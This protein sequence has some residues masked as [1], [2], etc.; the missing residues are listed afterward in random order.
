[1]DLL[2]KL[3]IKNLK[4][5]KKRTI[6]TIIGIM[7]SVALL[8]AVS[9]VYTSAIKSLEI[10][11]E[12]LQGNYHAQ[13][14]DVDKNDLNKF[15]DNDA[16]EHYYL[17]EKIGYSEIESKN[18]DKPYAYLEAYD[19]DSLKNVLV[20]LQKGRLPKNDSEIVIPTTL[21]TNGRN[22]LTIGDKI[23]LNVGKRYDAEGNELT[24]NEALTG[25]G[26]ET[27]KPEFTKEY[28]VVGIAGRQQYAVE[29][30]SA[31]G[32][33]FITYKNS[34]EFGDKVDVFVEFKRNKLK[35]YYKYIAGILEVNVDTFEKLYINQVD[36]I[37]EEELSRLFSEMEKAKY[38]YSINQ[39]LIELQINPIQG[40]AMGD[41]SK[42]VAI[43]LVIIVVTSVFC[44]KNSFDISITEKIK[45]YGMFRSVGA[46]KRQIRKNVLY[47]AFIL[48]LIGIPLGL[49][50]G[51]LASYILIIVSNALLGESFGAGLNL[52]FSINKYALLITIVL[53]F[54]TIYFSALK[55]AYKASKVSP[56][57]SIR[58]SSNIKIKRNSLKAPKIINKLFG[59]G[60]EIS[61]KNMKRN[62][63]KYRTTVISIIVSTAVFIALTSFM[64][65]GMESVK[66]EINNSDYN[67]STAVQSNYIKDID[68]KQIKNLEDAKKISINKN[69]YVCL[70][71]NVKYTKEYIDA[72]GDDLKFLEPCITIVGLEEDSYKDYLKLLKNKSLD[73]SSIILI[74]NTVVSDNDGKK[75]TVEKFSY[76]VGDKILFNDSQ[77]DNSKTIKI[78]YI[79]KI[80][81]FAFGNN[82]D[83]ILVVNMKKYDEFITTKSNL[84]I[85]VDSSNANKTQNELELA[86]NNNYVFFTNKDENVRLLSNFILLAGIFLYGFIIVIT[87]IGIT[88]I[89]NT[90][91]S[92]IS[93]RSQ[94]FAM[95]KSIGMTNKEFKNMI[96]LESLFIGTKSLLFGIP[97][98]IALSFLIYLSFGKNEAISFIFPLEA[99]IISM[100]AVL[101]LIYVI[102][103]YSVKKTEKQNIIETIRN[104][105]I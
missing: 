22:E 79:T 40:T 94:E 44:I 60:G 102:M 50:L 65:Y 4:L 74:N 14:Q 35:D 24:Q 6:V 9:I 23:T 82:V 68:L 34:K 62:K 105:N 28:T 37:S 15:K 76:K 83:S 52:I 98:G 84:F 87:L 96:K 85:Y 61:F 48:G 46:T 47:E 17:T 36:Y 30:Y 89:F 69:T 5:N 41:L 88:N 92:N 20:K 51:I 18:P 49:L 95:L 16:F 8:A 66:Q 56:I 70:D 45:Q 104:E 10:Y 12:Y 55:S 59:I 43:V 21:K 80:A 64:Q 97:I 53:G 86:V 38:V 93:L 54:I 31:P 91:T 100:I 26:V 72:I 39:Y 81:P 77:V 57:D 2:N 13:F 78:D 75:K 7:L 32:Y 63:K 71:K 1:M 19:E 3:T 11:E 73:T 99:I 33:T 29:D 103:N 25:Y 42:V 27:I 90:I 67:I 58:N 101:L